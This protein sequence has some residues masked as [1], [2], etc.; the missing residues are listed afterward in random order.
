MAPDSDWFEKAARLGMST[1]GRVLAFVL[2]AALITAWILTSPVFQLGDRFARDEKPKVRRP[3]SQIRIGNR[4]MNPANWFVVFLSVA[5][6]T[7]CLAEEIATETHT[8]APVVLTLQFADSTIGK[9]VAGE[10]FKAGEH[11]LGLAADAGCVV[12]CCF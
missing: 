3:K 9:E 2:I 11:S 7:S 12:S 6:F 10:G 1:V 8:G 4:M 5:S